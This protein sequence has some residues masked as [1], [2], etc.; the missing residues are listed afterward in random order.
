MIL[1]ILLLLDYNALCYT[2]VSIG[3]QT[4]KMRLAPR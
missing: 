3:N 1:M 4:T 2:V